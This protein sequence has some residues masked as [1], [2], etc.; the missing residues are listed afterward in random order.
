M[1]HFFRRKIGK[2]GF[3]LIELLVVVS[4]I[5]LLTA[6]VVSNLVMARSKARDTKRK[7]DLHQLAN[8]TELRF[9]ALATYP[10][11]AGW[12]SNAN[13]GGLDGSLTPTYIKTVSDDP[14]NTGNNV[15]MYWRKDYRGYTCL[16]AGTANQYGFY[17]RLENPKASDL[18]TIIDS[19]DACVRDTW[20]MN[21]K[22]GN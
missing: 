7:T 3:T 13:H 17:A 5:S 19:F 6:A 20:G 16:T 15:Y 8:A 2:R 9:N 14:L 21:Y 18:A 12:F 4:I 10:A 22:V 1:I 11:S